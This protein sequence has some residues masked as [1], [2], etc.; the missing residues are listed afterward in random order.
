MT[1]GNVLCMSLERSLCA[2]GLGLSSFRD[3]C[4]LLG[5]DYNTRMRGYGPKKCFAL[6]KAHGTIDEIQ[7]VKPDLPFDQL[8][9]EVCREIFEG[10]R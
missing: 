2:L 4:I 1:P 7:K 3:L 6:I 5:C 8:N 9:H 10:K